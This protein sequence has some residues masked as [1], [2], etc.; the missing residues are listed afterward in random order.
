MDAVAPM[1]TRLPEVAAAWHWVRL[2]SRRRWRALLVL[3]VL[4]AVSS[5]TVLGALAAA[6]RGNSALERLA[7]R[8]LPAT[9][10]VL[11]FGPGVDWA[12]VRALPEVD[13]LATYV[14]TDFPV[15]GIPPE[16]LSVGY[17][18]GDLELMRTIERPVVLEGRLADPARAD[19]AVVTPAFV[20]SYG[21]G[22]G[23]TVVA[24]LPTVEQARNLSI[25]PAV[26]SGPRIPIRIVGVVRSPWFADGP[27]SQGSL[28][29]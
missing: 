29:P 13:T 1:G 4:V 20:H 19:E 11:P 3:V 23:A 10:V 15:E 27:Q 18:P 26:G 14:D 8:T 22:V 28:L 24:D 25:T 9:V 16:N 12:A 17:P 2:D 5:G 21:K 6:R 7:R